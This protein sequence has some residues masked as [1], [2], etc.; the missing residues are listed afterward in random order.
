MELSLHPSSLVGFTT[1]TVLQEDSQLDSAGYTFLINPHT[2]S[3]V[4]GLMST[5]KNKGCANIK[6]LRVL[7]CFFYLEMY[8]LTHITELHSGMCDMFF[9][10]HYRF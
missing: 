4:C 8:L 3:S 6:S 2:L 5:S 7:F 9:E 1:L 10:T